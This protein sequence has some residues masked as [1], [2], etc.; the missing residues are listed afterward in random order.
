[1][2]KSKNKEFETFLESF[3]EI[4]LPITLTEDLSATFSSENRPLRDADIAKFIHTID[5]NIDE[6][7][8]YVPCFQLPESPHFKAVVFWKAMLMENKYVLALYSLQGE[9]LDAKVLSLIQ[10][11][12]LGITRS[13]ATIDEDWN[14]VIVKGTTK[15]NDQSYDPTLSKIVSLEITPEGRILPSD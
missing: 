13:V 6:F 7:T 3:P 8:E 15:T 9:P 2:I 14:I 12:S 11:N 1:M 4:D 5:A 10:H